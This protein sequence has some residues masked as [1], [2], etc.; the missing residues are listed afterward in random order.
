MRQQSSTG[1]T[2][3]NDHTLPLSIVVGVDLGTSATKTVIRL[4]DEP[5]RPT[6]AVPSPARCQAENHPY[7]WATDLWE[8]HGCYLREPAT[9]ARRIERIKERIINAEPDDM[10]PARIGAAYIA[11]V[12]RRAREWLESDKSEYLRGRE[13]I[14]TANIGIPAASYDETDLLSTYRA[15]G[16]AALKLV[17]GQQPIADAEVQAI[18][19]SNECAAACASAEEAG[20]QGIAIMPEIVGATTGFMQ[21]TDVPNHLYQLI[22]VGAWSLDTCTFRLYRPLGEPGSR[23]SIFSAKVKPLGALHLR[24]HLRI[25]RRIQDFVDLCVESVRATIR[26]TRHSMDPTAE[27]FRDGNPLPLFLTGGGLHDP[28]YEEVVTQVDRWLKQGARQYGVRSGGLQRL[29][30]TN[31]C[32][33]S[34]GTDLSRLTVAAGLSVPAWEMGE[35]YP[36]KAIEPFTAPHDPARWLSD[37]R[38]IGPEQM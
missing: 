19:S 29:A 35:I 12:L 6:F 9:G 30:P 24:E 14:W 37:D 27:A 33:G 34:E 25:R 31:P 15:M 38:Y 36:P 10:E 5:Q 7:L 18:W 4:P 3:G 26:E 23:Y 32:Q 8:R 13:P 2:G 28:A 21:S 20:Q 11:H 17:Q 22:D 1:R 16:A